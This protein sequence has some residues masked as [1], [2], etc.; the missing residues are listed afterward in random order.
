MRSLAATIL[1]A[2]L[3]G[4]S[5]LAAECPSGR[6]D[7]L[8]DE[9]ALGPFFRFPG[10]G[11][12]RAVEAYLASRGLMAWSADFVAD[13]WTHISAQQVL[14]RALAR[15]EERRKGVLLLHDIQPATALMLPQLL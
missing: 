7:A 15:L 11:R 6:H 3:M 5:A 14:H 13:D 1:I 9:R 4:G 10:L 8:G 12:S 2:T